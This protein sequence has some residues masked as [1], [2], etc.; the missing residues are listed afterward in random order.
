MVTQ[1]RRSRAATVHRVAETDI[2]VSGVAEPGAGI[3]RVAGRRR[4]P[5]TSWRSCVCTGHPSSVRLAPAARPL[6]VDHVV[7]ELKSRAKM[8]STTEE[9][10]QVGW[11]PAKCRS[12]SLRRPPAWVGH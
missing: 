5:G 6:Q 7:A 4:L 1:A 8:I 2:R 9:I 10:A 3:T 12:S 11:G